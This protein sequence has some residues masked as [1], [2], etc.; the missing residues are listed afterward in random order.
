[1]HGATESQSVALQLGDTDKPLKL[2]EMW[3]T[4]MS[5]FCKVD[6]NETPHLYLRRNVFLA[7]SRERSVSTEC[8]SE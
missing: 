1:M 8:V 4:L 2:I 3:P 7:V 6:Y 5:K